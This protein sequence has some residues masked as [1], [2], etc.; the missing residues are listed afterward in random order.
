MSKRNMVIVITLGVLVTAALV[1]MI[2]ITANG[3]P[4][5]PPIR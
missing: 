1:F 5:P 4:F 3:S 2:Y